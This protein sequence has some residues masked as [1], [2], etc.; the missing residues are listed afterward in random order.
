MLS[1]RVTAAYEAAMEKQA[2][3]PKDH[4]TRSK[5]LRSLS[6]KAMD[7][8]YAFSDQA[9]LGRR[10]MTS[11]ESAQAARKA[12]QGHR[13][14]EAGAAEYSA[15]FAKK[16]NVATAGV[17]R[18]VTAGEGLVAGARKAIQGAGQS[19]SA[20]G[21]GMKNGV[22]GVPLNKATVGQ[23]A[24]HWAGKTT[25]AYGQSLAKNPL[26]TAGA[27]AAGVG[28]AGYMATR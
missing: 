18:A 9:A 19:L 15:Y 22:R 25:Q 8:S 1:D 14:N 13:F 20:A 6:D 11:A 16:A 23:T 24:Q 4:F 27:T 17:G 26:T 10:A 2:I 7:R 28:A 5:W 12:Q 3:G 21:A